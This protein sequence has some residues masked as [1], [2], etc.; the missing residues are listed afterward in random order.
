MR[1]LLI[2]SLWAAGLLVFTLAAVVASHRAPYHGPSS[3]LQAPSS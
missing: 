2:A 3:A 1:K